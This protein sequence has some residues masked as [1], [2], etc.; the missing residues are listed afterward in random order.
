MNKLLTLT[1]LLLSLCLLSSCVATWPEEI[2]TAIETEP[3]GETSHAVQ[4]EPN[5]PSPDHVITLP[6]FDSEAETSPMPPLG[7]TPTADWLD[8]EA[9]YQ[10]L[11]IT[12]VY[13]T[14]KMPKKALVDASFVEIYNPTE[15]DITLGGAALYL[16][17]ADG[18]YVAHG[19]DIT[20]TIP[21]GGYFLV[22][23]MDAVGESADVFEIT[24]YDAKMNIRP[25]EYGMRLALAPVGLDLDASLPMAELE[26]VF[27]YVTSSPLDKDDHWHYVGNPTPERLIRKKANTQKVDY[28]R[29]DLSHASYTVLEQIRP[30]SAKGDQNRE[31][32][33]LIPEVV[34]SQSGGI[35]EDGFALT[36]TAPDGYEIYY[37]I[38]SD[39]PRECSPIRYTEP[40]Q[41]TDSQAMT[42][43]TLTKA[44]GFYMGQTYYPTAATFPG[45][46]VVRAYAVSTGD[47]EQ[48]HNVTPMTTQT[49][50]VGEMFASSKLDLVSVSLKNSD[51]LGMDGIYNN[52]SGS[53][54]EDRDKVPAYI[55]IF[56]SQE[57]YD[58][59]GGRVHAGWSEIAMNGKGSLSMTQKSFRVLFKN[60]VEGQPENSENLSTLAYDLFGDYAATTPD[61]E[62][63]TWYRHILLRNGGGDMSGST[64]SR[65]HIGDAYIQRLDRYLRCDMMASASVMVFVGGEFWGIFNARDRLDPKYFEGKY[66]ILEEEFTMLECPHPLVFGWNVDYTTSYGDEGAAAEFMALIDYVRTHDLAV[67][68]HYDYVASLV[69]IEGLIDFFCAQIYLC[70]SDWPANNIKVWRNENPNRMDTK[71]HFCIVD[72]DHGVGLNSDVNTNLFGVINDGSIMGSLFYRLC[73]NP[74]FK[75]AF[76]RRFIWCTEVYYEPSWML[77]ELHTMEELIDPY[78]TYQLSRWRVTDGSVTTYD[79]WYSYIQVIE[80]FALQ[81]QAHAKAQLKSFAGLT[82]NEYQAHLYLAKQAF[83]SHPHES[84]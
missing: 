71:W 73:G 77:S 37:T 68:E 22:R 24:H 81:R 69:D 38:N 25:S 17:D 43:G 4:T 44:C 21:A 1:A 9:A 60:Q 3:N 46:W 49:Y 58:A 12:S 66:G 63:I 59:T 47:G 75:T 45:A 20:D 72:T 32:Q 30:K 70:C 84:L 54:K 27:T 51:F 62:P 19:F 64:I 33:S 16:A 78:M 67:K 39:D 42:W 55:E 50:F 15:R 76:V 23:G 11:V 34:F 18:D 8:P 5:N 31:V 83:G 61:G 13:S 28:Q 79:K 2:E 29:I 74:T 52:A 36:L 10:K 56:T 6:V 26:G 41:I 48:T 65:S 14:G 82:E 35:Y 40:I 53:V 7:D 57:G 80:D